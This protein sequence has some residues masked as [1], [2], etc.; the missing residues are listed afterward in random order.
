MHLLQRLCDNECVGVAGKVNLNRVGAAASFVCAVHCMLT[1]VAL[2]FLSVFGLG[3]D[4]NP[5]ADKALLTVAIGVGSAAAWHGYRRHGSKVPAAVFLLGVAL[6][7][8][9][10]FGIPH[11][12]G[13]HGH[14]WHL[15]AGTVLSV[16]GGLMLVS[17][18]LLNMR[19]E[20][21][22]GCPA[23]QAEGPSAESSSGAAAPAAR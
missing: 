5:L 2:G 8:V 6:V 23:C 12:H 9:G 19:L 7:F 22:C 1:G 13:A 11:D 3:A 15:T 14:G 16:V 10:R 21:K 4:G 17:F 20:R 18:H